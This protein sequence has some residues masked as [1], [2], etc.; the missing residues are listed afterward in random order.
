MVIEAEAEGRDRVDGDRC[1]WKSTMG[2]V[3]AIQNGP[4]RFIAEGLDAAAVGPADGIQDVL[5]EA[6]NDVFGR[7]G[8]LRAD[9][10]PGS[11]RPQK[12]SIKSSSSSGPL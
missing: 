4:T 6:V 3:M 8:V 12:I 10:D 2:P 1:E 5:K 7:R 9:P 11:R